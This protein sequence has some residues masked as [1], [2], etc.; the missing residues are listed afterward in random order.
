MRKKKELV[1]LKSDKIDV[2]S[3]QISPETEKV[4]L[5]V[6]N[7]TKPKSISEIANIFNY[8]FNTA[9]FHVDELLNNKLLSIG[10]FL[11]GID[12]PYYINEN[13]RSYVQ[14]VIYKRL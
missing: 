10:N 7:S 6:Y 9:H 12:R 13:G 3:V 1:A 4:L 8:K 2:L 5:E 14:R 11:E